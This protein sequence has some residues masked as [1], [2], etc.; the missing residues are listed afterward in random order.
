MVLSNQSVST[1]TLGA[2]VVLGVGTAVAVKYLRWAESDTDGQR[3][4]VPTVEAHS[5]QHL[6]TLLDNTTDEQW[7]THIR[8]ELLRRART[9][10]EAFID[11]ATYMCKAVKNADRHVTREVAVD[12]LR[13]LRATAPDAVP[14]RVQDILDSL[15]RQ[16]G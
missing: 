11:D 14:E 16:R 10:P 15:D 1:R 5:N 9:N 4:T 8:E 7:T 12:I 2:A 6:V 13:R 3:L